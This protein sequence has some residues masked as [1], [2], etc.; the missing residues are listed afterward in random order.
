MQTTPND[1]F[2]NLHKVKI[3]NAPGGQVI[4]Q[5]EDLYI[6][7]DSIVT[8]ISIVRCGHN[9]SRLHTSDKKSFEVYESPKLIRNFV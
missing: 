5:G 3:R 7:I 9:Y 8:I 2:L 1:K 4:S 6:R